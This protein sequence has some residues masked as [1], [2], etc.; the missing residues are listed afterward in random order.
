[1]VL[2]T[3]AV[4]VFAA[5]LVA[6]PTAAGPPRLETALFPTVALAPGDL[7]HRQAALT[8]ASKVRLMVFWRSVAP[9]REPASWDP[10]DPAD[11]AYRWADV[12]VR[13]RRAVAGGLDP[14]L[15]IVMAPS[16]ATAPGGVGYPPGT[17]KP[18]A[19]D[20][21][22]FAL[23]AARRYSG[24]VQDLP[25]VR[26]WQAWNEPN[27]NRLPESADRRTARRSRPACTA[28][29]STRSP[30]PSTRFIG[31]NVV[32]GGGLAPFFDNTPEVTRQNDDWGP[33]TFMRNLL[34]L[35]KDLTPTC[36]NRVRFDVWSTHPYTSGGPTH[37]AIRPDDVSLGDLPE[38]R[39]VL[40]AAS[41]AHHIVSAHPSAVLGHGVQLG[42][43]A[44]R[45]G[46]VPRKL[47]KRWVP[48]AL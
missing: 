6:S 39:A 7:T 42:L 40:D 46:G 3:V 13:V 38:M 18:S 48:Q 2:R 35:A 10:A 43:E 26:Y 21:G 29:W 30:T 47:L 36:R 32:I 33:L 11:P 25:R 44:A 12:D 24:N 41:R 8:G 20:F 27:L 19:A 37:H 1:M 23:A 9:A 28:T 4:A 22:Q 15:T 31:D 16:W 34:C 5:L 14:I 17:Y 45:P